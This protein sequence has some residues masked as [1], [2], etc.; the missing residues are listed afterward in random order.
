MAARVA[1]NASA[2]R[3]NHSAICTAFH[4]DKIKLTSALS[5]ISASARNSSLIVQAV[6]QAGWVCCSITPSICIARQPFCSG[7]H[8]RFSFACLRRL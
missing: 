7:A 5:T 4:F 3:I 1:L 8:I 2:L 6:V